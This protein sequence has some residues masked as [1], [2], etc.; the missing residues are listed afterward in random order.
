[1][2]NVSR[3]IGN[4]PVTGHPKVYLTFKPGEEYIVCPYCSRTY[5]LK[6][7]KKIG[8]FA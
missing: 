7:A 5:Q 3:C 1:M 2:R 6:S 4:G 8:N